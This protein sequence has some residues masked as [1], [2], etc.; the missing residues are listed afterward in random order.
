MLRHVI[1]RRYMATLEININLVKILWYIGKSQGLHNT[2]QEHQM[3]NLMSDDTEKITFAILSMGQKARYKLYELL[4]FLEAIFNLGI[5]R[6]RAISHLQPN[7]C[8]KGTFWLI[9]PYGQLTVCNYH[10]CTVI[11]V[12]SFMGATSYVAGILA[13]FPPKCISSILGIWG[14]IF[15]WHILCNG[16]VNKCCSFLFLTD[17]CSDVGLYADYRQSAVGHIS[18]LSQS[19]LFGGHLSA[20]W[21]VCIQVLLITLLIALSS[22][23]V[24]ILISLFHM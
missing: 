8:S 10:L 17:V 24:Y 18:A 20:M 14:H 1:K 3:Y 19:Y 22:Y 6:G 5:D 4:S 13:Y 11:L 23:E 7:L 2:Q 9:W 12:T 15:C 16:M 21:N